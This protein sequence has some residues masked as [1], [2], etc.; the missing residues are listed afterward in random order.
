VFDHRI[1]DRAPAAQFLQ[2]I[3]QVVEE[4]YLLLAA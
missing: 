2:Y 1:I 3:K 4:P